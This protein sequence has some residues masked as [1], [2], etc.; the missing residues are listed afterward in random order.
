M[1]GDDPL[2]TLEVPGR[3]GLELVVGVN[4]RVHVIDTEIDQL[5]LLTLD[6]RLQQ[7]DGSVLVDD[8]ALVVGVRSRTSALP[9]LFESEFWLQR[10]VAVEIPCPHPQVQIP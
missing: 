1:T 6:Y 5:N 10:L 4:E 2:C 9:S 8:S 7:L 3:Q